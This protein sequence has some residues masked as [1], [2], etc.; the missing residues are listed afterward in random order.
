MNDAVQDPHKLDEF[1]FTQRIEKLYD[2]AWELTQDREFKAKYSHVFSELRFIATSIKDDPDLQNLQ[3]QTQKF[4]DNFTFNDAN[5]KRQ[6]NVDLVTQLRQ[7]VVPMFIAQL[8]QIPVPPIQGS[9]DEYDYYFDNLV[10]SG[11]D[12][13]PEM[14]EIHTRSDLAINLHKLETEQARSRALLQVTNIKPKFSDIHFKFDRKTF[15]KI[16]DE[17]MANLALSGNTGITIKILLDLSEREG[18]PYFSLSQAYVDIDKLDVEIISA[19]HEVLI[20]LFKTLY[21]TRVKSMIEENIA[22]KIREAFN[23]IENGINELFLRYPPSRLKEAISN[24][25]TAVLQAIQS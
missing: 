4:L 21:Q 8:D 23:K 18:L 11:R 24:Q 2:Q 20:K 25:P 16:S 9:T 10:F 1:E 15:P 7:L 17:G 6:F 3:E 19:H 13:I 12:I 14:V 22:L 5:G